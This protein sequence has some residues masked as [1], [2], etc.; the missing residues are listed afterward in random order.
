MHILPTLRL[1]HLHHAD[2]IYCDKREAAKHAESVKRGMVKSEVER[3]HRPAATH[4]EAN[5]KKGEI[6]TSG[7][8]RGEH[9]SQ[10]VNARR[11]NWRA[12]SRGAAECSERLK[13][14]QAGHAW[15]RCAS[16]L[17]Y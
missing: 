14:A 9:G 2:K 4:C 13:S 16:C 5:L 12:S 6:C 17:L 8:T 7:H 3:G 15:N 10:V 1:V 11:E